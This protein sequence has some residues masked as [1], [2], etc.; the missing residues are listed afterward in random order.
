MFSANGTLTA[1]LD[2]AP[3][4][5]GAVECGKT[6]VFTAKPHV[7]YHVDTWTVSKGALQSVIDTG[8]ETVSVKITAATTVSVSFG[9][10]KKVAFSELQSY[11]QKRPP[12]SGIHYIEVTGFPANNLAAEHRIQSPLGKI[13]KDNPSKRLC[14]NSAE[15]Y[16]GLW[17]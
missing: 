6:V 1:A 15:P 9:R 14:L 16:R 5:G 3:F 8:E 2:S 13:L 12:S 17:I 11:L 10:Y 4:I 7:D